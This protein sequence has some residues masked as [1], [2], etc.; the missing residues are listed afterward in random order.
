MGGAGIES[1]A[2]G[3]EDWETGTACAE[4]DNG[5]ISTVEGC[6]IDMANA[7]CCT[8]ATW[9]GRRRFRNRFVYQNLDSSP[10][11]YAVLWSA[12]CRGPAGAL[13]L[14]AAMPV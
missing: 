8:L 14:A 1:E 13:L 6:E 12:E 11:V 2:G 4:D 10:C 7:G 9:F 5:L 3:D